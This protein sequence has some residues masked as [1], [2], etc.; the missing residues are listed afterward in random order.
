VPRTTLAT[1]QSTLTA[2]VVPFQIIR[3]RKIAVLTV[4]IYDLAGSF[5]YCRQPVNS[6]VPNIFFIRR[7]QARQVFN[8]IARY[9]ACGFPRDD[10]FGLTISLVAQNDV[11]FLKFMG[12]G[13]W[14]RQ[15]LCLSASHKLGQQR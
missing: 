14:E 5:Q 7:P 11:C 6:A 15:S 8:N 9:G 10:K 1:E 3:K 4:Y 2:V 13:S 12:E